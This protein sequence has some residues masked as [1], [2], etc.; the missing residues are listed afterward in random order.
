MTYVLKLDSHSG[1]RN[2]SYD[3]RTAPVVGTPRTIAESRQ[4]A[5]DYG[6]RTATFRLVRKD[7]KL[8]RYLRGNGE[9][10]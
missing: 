1:M 6:D 10:L 4:M 5:R 2:A 7:G 8:N 9:D 3:R